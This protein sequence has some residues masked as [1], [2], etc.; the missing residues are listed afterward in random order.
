MSVIYDVNRESLWAHRVNEISSLNYNVEDN[1]AVF[2]IDAGANITDASLNTPRIS[3][4]DVQNINIHACTFDDF[5][6]V[7]EFLRGSCNAFDYD[8]SLLES[9]RN[10]FEPEQIIDFY[11][12]FDDYRLQCAQKGNMVLYHEVVPLAQMAENMMWMSNNEII[13]ELTSDGFFT[14][15]IFSDV[16]SLGFYGN[17]RLGEGAYDIGGNLYDLYAE[18]DIESTE[19]NP[20]VAVTISD[21]GS[22]NR[23]S[24]KYVVEINSIDLKKATPIELYAYFSY[25]DS[26]SNEDWYNDYNYDSTFR[27]IYNSNAFELE[28]IEDFTDK[29]VNL[30]DVLT[31]A[32]AGI[33]SQEDSAIKGKLDF[34]KYLNAYTKKY[35]ERCLEIY[36]EI[37]TRLGEE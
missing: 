33:I 9:F 22:E 2:D 18:Y 12:F 7:A 26:K 19:E 34:S 32:K 25:Y 16:C 15:N 37:L 10:Q 13:G 23:I 11:E 21:F 31:K 29:Q 28:G 24:G 36:D 14:T 30:F 27:R 35:I 3:Y 5:C 17:Y 4:F 6:D 8:K 20:I 1:K